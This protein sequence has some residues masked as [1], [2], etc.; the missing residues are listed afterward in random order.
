MFAC[1]EFVMQHC[2]D[3]SALFS[4]LKLWTCDYR[5]VMG[6]RGLLLC[7]VFDSGRVWLCVRGR[8]PFCIGKGGGPP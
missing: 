7:G 5:A 8:Y 6:D 1:G 2:A 4:N 3:L